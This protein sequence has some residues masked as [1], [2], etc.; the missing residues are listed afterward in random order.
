MGQGALLLFL[1]NNSAGI[2]WGT[3]LRMSWVLELVADCSTGL[4]ICLSVCLPAC[5]SAC[6]SVCLSIY[7]YG[8]CCFLIYLSTNLSLDPEGRRSTIDDLATSCHHLRLSPA[9]LCDS[10]QSSPAHSLTSCHHL[11]LSPT[12]LCDW[13]VQSCPLLTLSSHRFPFFLLPSQ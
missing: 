10:G 5:R 1:N 8:C 12:A 3:A 4:S 9:A 2:A 11:R 13:T 6:L 7:P